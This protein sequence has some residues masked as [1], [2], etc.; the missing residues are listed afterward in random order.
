MAL[1]R[2]T[3]ALMSLRP[4]VAILSECANPAILAGHGFSPESFVWV[5]RNPQKGLG[6]LAF[7][8]LSASLDP[9]Y[10]PSITFAAPVRIEG[11]ERLSVLAVWAHYHLTPYRK[12]T[13]GPAMDAVTRYASFLTSGPSLMAGDFNHNVRWDKPGWASNHA[14]FVQAA[15]RLSLASSYHH[16]RGEEQGKEAEPTLYWQTRTMDGRRYHIDYCFMSHP[17]LARVTGVAV[18]SYEDW[19][20]HLSDHVPLV[21]DIAEPA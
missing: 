12:G 13:P 17:L 19:I 2:K 5:G 6:I 15:A 18:G 16:V 10:D 11:R 7:N 3:A 9:S 14:N 1:H 21:I 20:P 4:D 8:R